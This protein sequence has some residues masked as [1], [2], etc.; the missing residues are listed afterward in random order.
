[1]PSPKKN[2]NSLIN[3]DNNETLPVPSGT[4]LEEIE[5]SR[6]ENKIAL[7]LKNT[8]NVNEQIIEPSY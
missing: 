2:L 5:A 7:A 3:I 8:Q 1:M 4:S 6:K